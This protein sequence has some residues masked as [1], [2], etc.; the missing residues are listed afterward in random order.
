MT[1][2]ASSNSWEAQASLLCFLT[3]VDIDVDLFFS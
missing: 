2:A 3:D 1:A